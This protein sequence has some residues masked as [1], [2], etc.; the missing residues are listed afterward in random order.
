MEPLKIN[1]FV[2]K[3]SPELLVPK[4]KEWLTAYEAAHKANPGDWSA[5]ELI[6]KNA[7]SFC[8]LWMPGLQQMIVLLARQ[9]AEEVTKQ[10]YAAGAG[11]PFPDIVVGVAPVAGKATS[12]IEAM[13]AKPHPQRAVQTVERDP[14]TLEVVRTVTQYE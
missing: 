7:L 8:E 5:P 11:R 6:D 10:A 13:P 3:V 1:L 12:S 9:I 4:A 14:Q 2:P